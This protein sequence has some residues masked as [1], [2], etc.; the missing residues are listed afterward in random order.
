M[1]AL[2]SVVVPVYNNEVY[3]EK[4]IRSIMEQSYQNL[5]IL[6]INDGSKDHSF[7]I[8]TK[9]AE[10]DTR[11]KLFDQE[12]AGVA[13]ARNMGLEH[14]TGE[15]VTFID[16]DDYVG[17]N[18]ISNLCEKAESQALEM[19]I[20]GLKFVDEKECILRTVIP[21]K[22]RRFEHEEW[23]FRI[24]AVCSHFYRRELWEKHQIRFFS[25][26]RG[27][28]M[29][30]SMFFSAVCDKIGILQE[31]EYYYVQH[32]SSAMHN[33]K[34]LKNYSLPYRA[35]EESLQKIKETGIVNSL[36]F[37]E[38]F[39]LRI[40]STC[41]FDLARGCNRDKMKELCA[42]IIRIL[43]E[44]FPNYYKNPI[45]A[46]SAEIDVPFT[47]KAAV[48]LLIFLVRTRLIYPVSRLMSK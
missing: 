33:F 25:G 9:L 44:Y 14:A 43:E 29:P 23:T 3:V 12:N 6:V 46:F 27:E 41:F 22:Y 40:L 34:G 28:D 24:S 32:S 37:Y 13:A 48:K 16:G 7:E 42:Y 47:Q 21:G 31:A 15:Y 17:R 39:V 8:L 5:E 45:T 36:E 20:C 4:C 2:V 38:L 35:L 11:I 26:E 1:A 18:Y 10:E 30:I 19:V